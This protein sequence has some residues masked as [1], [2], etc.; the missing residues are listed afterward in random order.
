MSSTTLVR[1]KKRFGLVVR[2]CRYCTIKSATFPMDATQE[3]TLAVAT[4][5]MMAPVTALVMIRASQISRHG[6]VR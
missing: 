6:S 1:S 5:S 3:T 4:V 2:L